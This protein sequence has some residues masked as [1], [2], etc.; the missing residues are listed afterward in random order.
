[1]ILYLLSPRSPKHFSPQFIDLLS[2]GDSNTHSKKTHA[3]R[4][5]E[6]LV[7][8][9]KPL[10]KL[11]TDKALD[12]CKNGSHATLL[13]QIVNSLQGQLIIT[14]PWQLTC[15]YAGDNDLTPLYNN[16]LGGVSELMT[17]PSGHCVLRRLLE[18]DKQKDLPNLGN[19]TSTVYS[20]LNN[21][22]YSVF[23]E[24]FKAVLTDELVLDWVAT[25]RGAFVLAR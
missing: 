18:G 24:L 21:N 16:I 19:N 22:I 6:L 20:P 4:W 17:H 8:V 10:I 14:L 5:G 2:P 12:W 1:M 23:A 25:N 11:V 15:V 3:I 13:L 9:A 7:G